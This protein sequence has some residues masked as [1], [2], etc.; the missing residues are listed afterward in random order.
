V[1]GVVG[2]ILSLCVASHHSGLIDCIAPVGRDKLS[3]R[4]LKAD[5][6]SHREEALSNAEPALTGTIQ[7]LLRDP[8]LVESLKGK[9]SDLTNG[10]RNETIIR[11]KTG[12]LIRL[13]FSCLIDADRTDTADFSSPTAADFR[14]HGK[15]V[16]WQ[17]LCSLLEERLLDFTAGNSVDDLRKHVSDECLKGAK[18][19]KGIFTLT[20]PTGGGKTLASLRFALNHAA[21]WGMDRVIYVS[22]YTSIIDQNAEVVRAILE[23][24]GSEFASVVLEHHSNL[25]P[26][27]QTWRSKILSENWDAPVVFTTMVQLLET[28]FGSGTRAVRRMHQMANAVLIFD[29]VQTVPIRCVH[30]FN[31]AINYLVEQCGSSAV[32][33]TAT[34]PLLHKVDEK[35]GAIR[36]SGQAELAGDVKDLFSRLRRYEALDC[37]RAGGWEHEDAVELAHAEARETGSC[38]VVVNTKKEALSIFNKYLERPGRFSAVHL[39]TNMCPAHRMRILNEVKDQIKRGQPVV[40]VSTQLIEAGVDIDF[41]GVIRALAGLDSIAQA[42]GRCNRNGL[43]DMGRVHIINLAGDL[44]RQLREISVAQESAQ[45]VLDECAGSSGDRLVDLSDP[46][47][48]ERYFSYYF[49]DRKSEM[50]YSVSAKEAERDDNLLNML[51]ENRLAVAEFKRAGKAPEICLRQSFMSAAKAFEPIEA[52]TRGVIVPYGDAGKA[53][54][55]DLFAAFEADKEF[56]LLKRAQQFTVNVFPHVLKRLEEAQA[57]REVK[58]G[59]GILSLNERYYSNDFGLSIEGSEE[60]EL[61]HV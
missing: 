22:P 51:S 18:R 33:C 44:P 49:F 12:L 45:R 25:T 21:T 52:D 43:R 28:L 47:L 15:Y 26:L 16:D 35:K 14:Q 55:A 2:E 24:K 56:S 8:C 19:P 61:Q 48:T 1:E 39:S 41:G 4:M 37:R 32:L 38:L 3:Y 40:C 13:L 36:L 42:A 31:N 27:K 23:P 50:S 29:E 59:T 54:I 11:F 17:D 9:L 46:E 60:M 53:I 57:V 34:Q 7:D 5:G 6:D 30:L 20:V 10:D 58:P